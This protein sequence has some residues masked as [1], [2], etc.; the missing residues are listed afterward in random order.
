MTTRPTPATLLA[1]VLLAAL[2][3]AVGSASAADGHAEVLYLRGDVTAKGAGGAKALSVGTKLVPGDTIT[4]GADSGA[5]LRLF[6][7]LKATDHDHV[8]VKAGTT[9]EIASLGEGG[10]PKKGVL[11]LLKGALSYITGGSGEV[12]RDVQVKTRTTIGGVRGTEFRIVVEASEATRVETL[13]GTVNVAG[14]KSDLDVTAGSGSRVAADAEP[15]EL[16]PL[17]VAPQL[18]GRTEGTLDRFRLQW[19]AVDGAASYV[20]EI[21]LEE[22][23]TR[24]VYEAGEEATTHEPVS[25]A[26]P[27]QAGTFFWRVS[28]VDADGY[29][30]FYSRPGSFRLP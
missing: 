26:L 12:E 25:V 30:G 9:L 6:G 20:V 1:C 21:A 15:E 18:A 29:Q 3:G 28:A 8:Q 19:Q 5:S 17:P 14:A 7:G 4:A 10:G 27:E 11:S 22:S 16:H 23:F 24:I 13:E 2:L